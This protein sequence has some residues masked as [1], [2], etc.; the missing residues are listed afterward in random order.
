MVNNEFNSESWWIVVTTWWLIHFQSFLSRM[1]KI[2]FKHLRVTINFKKYWT[3]AV[4]H[5]IL[6]KLAMFRIQSL[7]H[8]PAGV[9]ACCGN[10]RPT[11]WTNPQQSPPSEAS[12]GLGLGTSLNPAAGRFAGLLWP[13]L[14][15]PAGH[16]CEWRTRV[17][18]DHHWTCSEGEITS[19]QTLLEKKSIWLHNW[20]TTK[21][22][23]RGTRCTSPPLNR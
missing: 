20:A 14:D 22:P 3:I 21:C 13:P 8:P 12:L 7:V 11:K 6:T 16:F 17:A 1:W 2:E 10:P 23:W 5:S 4:W 9:G 18:N 15:H 19:A